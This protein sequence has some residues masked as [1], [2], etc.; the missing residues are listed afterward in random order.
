MARQCIISAGPSY[1]A[2][3]RRARQGAA[4]QTTRTCIQGQRRYAQRSTSTY[5]CRCCAGR[6]R[7]LCRLVSQT[8][9][10]ASLGARFPQPG[11]RRVSVHRRESEHAVQDEWR[12]VCAAGRCVTRHVGGEL[13]PGQP[14]SSRTSSA[15]LSMLLRASSPNSRFSVNETS[16]PASTMPPGNA[17]SPLSLRLM[18]QNSRTAGDTC[19]ARQA[20]PASQ[21]TVL[22]DGM[23]SGR[24]WHGGDVKRG[25]GRM[26]TGAM[27][28]CRTGR[29]LV[30]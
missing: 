19:P 8:G 4:R 2:R 7:S 25:G 24:T 21:T 28:S 11:A 26:Q 18:R 20:V 9:K 14:R 6:R 17:H 29:M 27:C 1:P 12:L 13:P 30:C 23:S 10:D 5:C 22:F 16:S 15:L 3:Q